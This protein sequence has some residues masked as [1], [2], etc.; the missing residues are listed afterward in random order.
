MMRG[1]AMTCASWSIRTC[2]L[3]D[4]LTVGCAKVGS[5]AGPAIRATAMAMARPV[6]RVLTVVDAAEQLGVR[7]IGL[8]R[9]G[10]GHHA[11]HCPRYRVVDWPR[12]ASDN[13]LS[14]WA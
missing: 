12:A 2:A 6:W 8:D 10:I 7:L 5:C 13:V 9:P 4:E 3:A 11:H 1:S 14:C